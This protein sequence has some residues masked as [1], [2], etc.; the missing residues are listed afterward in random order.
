[1]STL[2]YVLQ[3]VDD[4]E[5][6]LHGPYK[7]S[8]GRDKKAKRLRKECREEFKDGLYPL[9]LCVNAGPFQTR[10]NLR[11]NLSVSSYSGGFFEED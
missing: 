9:D 2:Y 10:A 11:P 6:M 8:A 4:V 5:P 1:M 7:T 3:V